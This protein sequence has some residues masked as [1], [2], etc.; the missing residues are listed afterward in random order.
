MNKLLVQEKFQ[1][2]I[3]QIELKK[4]LILNYLV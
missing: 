3:I 4:K 1:Q 2:F